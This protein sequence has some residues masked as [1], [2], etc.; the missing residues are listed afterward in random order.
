[1]GHPVYS[2]NE[3]GEAM[4]A[5]YIGLR[6]YTGWPQESKPLYRTINKSC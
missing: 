3:I 6:V 4:S 2:A 5:S 1:M